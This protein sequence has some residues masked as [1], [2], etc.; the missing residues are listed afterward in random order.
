VGTMTSAPPLVFAGMTGRIRA[1]LFTADRL[2]QY[3][4]SLTA[5]QTITDKPVQGRPLL[6]RDLENGQVLVEYY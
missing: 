1:E 4:E 3:A 2:E 6:P 5:A